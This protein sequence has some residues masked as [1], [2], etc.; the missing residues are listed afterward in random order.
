[1]DLIVKSDDVTTAG[2]GANETISNEEER[3]GEGVRIAG[4]HRLSIVG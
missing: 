3:G 4:Y 2:A 1:M